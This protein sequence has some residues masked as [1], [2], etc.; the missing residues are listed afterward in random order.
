MANEQKTV[1]IGKYASI[2]SVHKKVAIMKR[3]FKLPAFLEN[4]KKDAIEL[5][6]KFGKKAMYFY[7]DTKREN[8][9]ISIYLYVLIDNK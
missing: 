6:K 8:N 3:D 1:L 7:T 5:K 4:N 2:A 9:K